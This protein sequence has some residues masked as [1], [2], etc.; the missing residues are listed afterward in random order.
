MKEHI[1]GQGVSEERIFV[2]PNGA[3]LELFDSADQAG[4]R[5]RQQYEWLGDR[6]L[7][8]SPGTI[9]R[10]NNVE[11]LVELA[12][13]MLDTDPEGPFCYRRR[14]DYARRCS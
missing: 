7:V 3:D 14:W 1:I 4:H 10:V 9:G 2:I 8:L 6:P 12:G 5:I 13:T 11:F